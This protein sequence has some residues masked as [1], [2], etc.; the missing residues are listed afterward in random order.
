MTDTGRRVDFYQLA[1]D[2]PLARERYACRLAEKA[3]RNGFRPLLLAR[4]EAH[5]AQLDDLLW[6]FA[7]ESF[8]PHGR[9]ATEPVRVATRE[10]GSA[11]AMLI[12]LADRLPTADAPCVRIAEI[13]PADPSARSAARE[14]YRTWQQRG[15][16][17]HYHD[18]GKP[19]G[20]GS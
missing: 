1:G 17:V 10:G 20:P 6:S 9:D 13:V 11:H 3:L 12:N 2:G 5:A 4:D 8:L 16:A 7:P 19:R 15:W 18:L 14:A